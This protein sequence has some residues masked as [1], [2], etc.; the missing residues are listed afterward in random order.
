M[1]TIASIR[2]KRFRENCCQQRCVEEQQQYVER[3]SLLFCG[4]LETTRRATNQN[5][6]SSKSC[7]TDRSE[8]AWQGML[9][10][11]VYDRYSLIFYFVA[12]KF[13]RYISTADIRSI[14]NY[15]A[16]IL[17]WWFSVND[18]QRVTHTVQEGDINFWMKRSSIFLVNQI[19]EQE[20]CLAISVEIPKQSG[21]ELS[22]KPRTANLKCLPHFDI[23]QVV[24]KC[25]LPFTQYL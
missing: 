24:E 1:S 22:L 4:S 18:Y 25:I 16:V 13:W 21:Q 10:Y 19:N 8:Q 12:A 14:L 17:N 6:R 7:T 2:F 20:P 15:R 23:Y 11:T 3:M 9:L 5:G